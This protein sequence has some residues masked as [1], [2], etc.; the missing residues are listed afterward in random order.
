M[1][2]RHISTNN[3]V[4]RCEKLIVLFTKIFSAYHKKICLLMVKI[5]RRLAEKLVL[6]WQHRKLKS[7]LRFSS[8]GA[9]VRCIGLVMYDSGVGH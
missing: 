7:V 1:G 8:A 9:V 6:T 5:L 3:N 4:T 2:S